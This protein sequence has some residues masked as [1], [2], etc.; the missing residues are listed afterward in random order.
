MQLRRLVHSHLL[1]S[2]SPQPAGAT[3]TAL[4]ELPGGALPGLTADPG[5]TAEL[6]RSAAAANAASWSRGATAAAFLGAAA[7]PRS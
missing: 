6:T 2:A 3:S 7:P 4:P 5:L 1:H